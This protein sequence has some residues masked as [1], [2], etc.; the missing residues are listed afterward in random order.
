MGV[1]QS[2]SLLMGCSTSA[3]RFVGRPL[4]NR[5]NRQSALHSLELTTSV[6]QDVMDFIEVEDSITR[7]PCGTGR[8]VVPPASST[9]L[10]GSVRSSLSQPLTT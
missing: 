1:P 8:S 10:H 4:S 7:I 6:R 3:A 2:P 9:P 5:T